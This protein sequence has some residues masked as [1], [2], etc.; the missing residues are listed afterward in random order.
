MTV[1]KF[2]VTAGLH[3]GWQPQQDQLVARAATAA[4]AADVAVVVASAPASE[5]WDRRSLALP[6]AGR[7]DLRV[8]AANPRTVVVLNTSSAVTMPSLAQ[9][10][11]VF[12]V[13][14]PGQ[15]A[16]TAIS[17]VATSTLGR[18]R[19][20]SPATSRAAHS[21]NRHGHKVDDPLPAVPEKS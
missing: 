14:F 21:R 3:L 2:A 6:A 12:E 15:T 18:C 19:S 17:R 10:A 7:P 16:G 8:A 11:G 5:G 13:W 9:V 1:E 4:K 20:P